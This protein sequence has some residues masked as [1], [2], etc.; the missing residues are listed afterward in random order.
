LELADDSKPKN[1]LLSRLFRA[2]YR[3]TDCCVIQDQGRFDALSKVVH[4]THPR[5][6]FVPNAPAGSVVQ[7]IGE[8]FYRQRLQISEQQFPILVV[9]AGIVEDVAYSQELA[10]AFSEIDLGCALIFHERFTRDPDDPYLHRMRARNTRNLFFSLSPVPFESID[11][12][13]ASAT[14]GL[15]F[16][17]PVDANLAL[18]AKASGK[19]AFHLKH[20]TPMIMNDLPSLVELNRM[21]E[22]GVTV[23][24]PASSTELAAAV[25]FCMEN[26]VRLSANARTCF[27]R[28]FQLEGKIAPFLD[29]AT[30]SY[31]P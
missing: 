8:N 19:L 25:R 14:I 20:G 23:R 1:W 24:D 18:M 21:Y 27:E 3:R 28:E 4:Y 10:A 9:H 11:L 13:F 6:F 29:F 7:S 31:P 15:A 12:V 17:R 2:A 22:F 26:Y 30:K 5:V 16:Y